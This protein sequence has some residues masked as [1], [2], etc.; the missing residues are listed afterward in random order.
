M[1]DRPKTVS[2][3]DPTKRT[4]A[5]NSPKGA[6]EPSPVVCYWN[7]NRYSVGATVCD[8]GSLLRCEPD[9]S[10]SAVGTC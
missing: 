9:G 2:P 3:V 5:I 1:S 7:G 4:S 8:N 6:S 10:W